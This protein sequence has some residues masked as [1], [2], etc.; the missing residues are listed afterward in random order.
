MAFKDSDLATLADDFVSVHDA[1]TLAPRAHERMHGGNSGVSHF[2]VT[3]DDSDGLSGLKKLIGRA[4][5][6]VTDERAVRLK[7][8]VETS[9]DTKGGEY[10]HAIRAV[11]QKKNTREADAGYFM[12]QRSNECALSRRAFLDT[13]NY[14]RHRS[15]LTVESVR[16]IR[17]I[18]AAGFLNQKQLAEKF[19]VSQPTIGNIIRGDTWR[20]VLPD[21]ASSPQE[22]R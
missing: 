19:G 12:D 14:K 7:K 3:H 17:E 22:P 5:Y 18:Y 9:K 11:R 16:K 15:K 6:E 8:L 4:G 2:K 20:D 13:R 21:R 1:Q 10:T